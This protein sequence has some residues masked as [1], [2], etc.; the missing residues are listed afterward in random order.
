VLEEMALVEWPWK[1]V[2][3]AEEVELPEDVA[4]R[5]VVLVVPRVL[6]ETELVVLEE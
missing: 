6:P 2:E 4:E 1:E 5:V 3:D